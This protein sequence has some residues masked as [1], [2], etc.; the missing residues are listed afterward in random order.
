[1]SSSVIMEDS[2]QYE[3]NSGSLNKATTSKTTPHV[4]KTL[5]VLQGYLKVNK[6]FKVKEYCKKNIKRG[7]LHDIPI[8]GLHKK[9]SILS[10]DYLSPLPTSP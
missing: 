6:D 3:L 10:P 9:S 8:I 7:V 2:Y 5:T 4:I 1:M